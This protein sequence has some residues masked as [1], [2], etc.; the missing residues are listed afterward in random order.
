LSSLDAAGAVLAGAHAAK[1]VDTT[2][3]IAI[4]TNS[5]LF[6]N[7]YSL[8]ENFTV[9]SDIT[10]LSMD[11]GYCGRTPPLLYEGKTI[12]YNNSELHIKASTPYYPLSD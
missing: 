9:D 3:K 2:I 6:L 10:C 7:I 4:N 5:E 11:I 1:I 8:L 12:H